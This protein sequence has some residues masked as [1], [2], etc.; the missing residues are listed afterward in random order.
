MPKIYQFETL[1]KDHDKFA[2]LRLL[3]ETSGSMKEEEDNLAADGEM[4]LMGLLS[5]LVHSLAP[6]IL[7]NNFPNEYIRSK[8]LDNLTPTLNINYSNVEPARSERCNQS[9]RIGNYI[10]MSNSTLGEGS[11]STV[12]TA[13]HL[14]TNRKVAVKY[15]KNIEL[16]SD[17]SCAKR[18][19]REIMVL[20]QLRHPYICSLLE[21]VAT[22][23]GV[24]MILEYCASGDL[25]HLIETHG[26]LD[27]GLSSNYFKQIVSALSY[28][29]AKGIVHRGMLNNYINI[30]YF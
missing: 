21:V 30:T 28:C 17:K 20:K 29:H 14:E 1:Q 27:E 5:E 16:Y 26:K 24:H 12:Q 19:F 4:R 25:F 9:G 15:F 10:L 11:F 2:G 6:P 18:A 13:L 23:S 22:N 3:F 8:Q 7:N